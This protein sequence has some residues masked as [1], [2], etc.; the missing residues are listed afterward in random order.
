M[1]ATGVELHGIIGLYVLRLGGGG[2]EMG[3]STIGFVYNLTY[4]CVCFELI[5]LLSC[6][7]T[8]DHCLQPFHVYG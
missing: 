6:A 8:S 7:V 2:L 4:A 1:M 5:S 3:L